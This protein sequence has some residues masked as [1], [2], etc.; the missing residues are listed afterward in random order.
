MRIIAI[1][2]RQ[3]RSHLLGLEQLAER[4]NLELEYHQFAVLR[5]ILASVLKSEFQQANIEL[6]RAFRFLWLLLQLPFMSRSIVVLGIAPFDIRILLLAPFL[7]R[8]RVCL[9]NSWPNWGP[10][11]VSPKSKLRGI[12]YG[13][14][15]RLIP[16]LVKRIFCVSQTTADSIQQY[17]PNWPDCVVVAHSIDSAWFTANV[18][19]ET[20]SWTRDVAFVG[21]MVPEKGIDD[22]IKLA[23]RLPDFQFHFV[24]AGPMIDV[25]ESAQLPNT[26]CYG[27]ILS[28]SELLQILDS[29]SII[30]Q[31]S[32]STD[33][34][35]EAFGIGVLEGMARGLV[36]ITTDTTGS[37]TVLGPD[38]RSLAVPH[39]DYVTQFLALAESLDT[40][41]TWALR[42]K[43]RDRADSF[44]ASAIATHWESL[45]DV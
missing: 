4:Q 9:H 31:P 11:E 7:T 10:A 22:L 33:N 6:T 13:L 18:A 23:R 5:P 43:C 32:R 24:G 20:K 42:T 21:R 1:Q 40:P 14:W 17:F 25:V 26:K 15:R 16:R 30:A 34:W 19:L 35:T 38:L 27:Q 45:L 41:A 12:S 44:S 28:R 37:I 36:P 2:E 39:I 29:C 8:H 3:I